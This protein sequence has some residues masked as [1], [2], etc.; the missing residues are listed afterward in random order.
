MDNMHKRFA[1]ADFKA[2]DH[3]F[4]KEQFTSMFTKNTVNKTG[5]GWFEVVAIREHGNGLYAD[6]T[7]VR[8]GVNGKPLKQNK[9]NTRIHTNQFIRNNAIDFVSK[10]LIDLVNERKKA[11]KRG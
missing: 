8:L 10:E 11:K 4:M 5:S 9:R 7:L 2:G 3:V 6:V 1:S